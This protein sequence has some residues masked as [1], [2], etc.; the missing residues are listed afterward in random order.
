MIEFSLFLNS[1]CRIKSLKQLLRTAYANAYNPQRLEFLIRIDTD[2]EETINGLKNVH[3][4]FPNVYIFTST[5]PDN[6]HVTLNKLAQEA[7]G[8][9]LF[10]MN[11]DVE[12]ETLY[13]DKKI[14][15]QIHTHLKT[16]PDKILYVATPDNSVD[17]EGDKQYAS[18]PILTR[19]ARDALGY[20]MSEQFVG[21]GADEH[22]YRIF[23]SIGRVLHIQDVKLN[24][25]THNT[26]EKVL[27][28]DIFNSDNV[29]R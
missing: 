20:F 5:R 14:A 29:A 12:F 15:E 2:D 27:N 1:R 18:F 21:L 8:E 10:V 19:A 4:F 9:F 24:H 16:L 6:L 7:T 11:D 26:I 23:N 17:K 22:L 3:N 13:W 25:T 28:P